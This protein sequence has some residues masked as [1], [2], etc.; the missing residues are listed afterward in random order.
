MLITSQPIG[1]EPARLGPGRE[2]RPLDHDDGASVAD[3]DAE[4]AGR[5]DEQ[6]PQ[7]GAVRVGGGHVRHR[8]PS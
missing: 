7:V 6:P 5:L 3:G 8:A 4:L 1:L 2:A